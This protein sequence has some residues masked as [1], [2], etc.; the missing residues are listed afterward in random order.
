MEGRLQ[1]EQR[2]AACRLRTVHRAAAERRV[3]NRATGGGRTGSRAAAGEVQ[4][5]GFYCLASDVAT[6]RSRESPRAGGAG[7]A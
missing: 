6:D 5:R 2:A 1:D 3:E 4:S 7:Y